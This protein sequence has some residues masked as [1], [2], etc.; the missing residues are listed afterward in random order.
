[1]MMAD[2]VANMDMDLP[3][4][5]AVTKL[6]AKSRIQEVGTDVGE[7][8]VKGKKKTQTHKAGIN[9]NNKEKKGR[10]NWKDAW[11]V[12]LIH[13]CEAM[14]NKFGKTPKQGVYLWSKV[15]TQLASLFL[16]CDKD[17]QAC[18]KK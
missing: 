13:V 5:R 14:H 3:Q 17:G 2:K 18:K 12:E 15:A 8:G 1:M 6:P 4:Q 11:L 7:K 10:E 9:E 16:H